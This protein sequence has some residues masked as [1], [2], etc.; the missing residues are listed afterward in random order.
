MLDNSTLAE[1][2]TYPTSADDKYRSVESTVSTLVDEESEG[3]FG[4]VNAAFRLAD[5]RSIAAFEISAM[6][7]VKHP[8]FREE[9]EASIAD[10]AAFK[11]YV[12][13]FIE[14]AE[15]ALGDALTMTNSVLAPVAVAS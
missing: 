11:A 12:S 7:W 15:T 4:E 14:A 1:F 6:G 13:E 9:V 10:L 3:L 5:G 2:H 8:Q